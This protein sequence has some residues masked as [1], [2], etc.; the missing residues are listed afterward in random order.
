MTVVPD[1]DPAAETPVPDVAPAP[2]PDDVPI[3]EGGTPSTV[4]STASPGRARTGETRT[5]GAPRG[6]GSAEST[7]GAWS[8]ATATT[9]ILK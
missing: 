9:R 8:A 7:G 3:E 4:T 6:P 5:E 2:V 1:N